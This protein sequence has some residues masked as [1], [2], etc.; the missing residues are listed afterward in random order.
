MFLTPAPLCFLKHLVVLTFC[1][2]LPDFWEFMQIHFVDGRFYVPTYYNGQPKSQIDSNTILEHNKLTGGFRLTQRRIKADT[3]LEGR[4][5]FKKFAPNCYGEL[6]LDGMFPTNLVEKG[7]F[8]GLKSGNAYKY[9]QKWFWDVGYYEEFDL[10]KDKT[11][12]RLQTLKED[13][14]IGPATQWARLDFVLYNPN[15]GMFAFVQATFEIRPTGLIVPDFDVTTRR[16]GY[17][18]AT[19]DWSRMAVELAVVVGWVMYVYGEIGDA[20]HLYK[21]SG[22]MLAYLTDFWNLVDLI[23]LIVNGMLI[24]IWIYMITD[25]TI[26]ELI[27]TET[28]MTMGNG[29]PLDFTRTAMAVR[30][31]FAM[32]GFNILISV[33][34]ILKFF[35]QNAYLGQLTDAFELMRPG[36][37]QFAVVLFISIFMFTAMG[38][39]LFGAKL[40]DFTAFL[41]AVD[42]IMG[43]T[44]GYSD[45]MD[46]FAADSIS[47]CVFYY[48]FT[49]L[50]AFFVLPLTIAVIMDGYS[51]M[52]TMYETARVTNLGDVIDLSYPSQIYRGFV[53]S[54]QFLYRH[55]YRH[56]RLKFPAK[57][58]IL[59]LFADM[60]K[61]DIVPFSELRK[62]F[63][64][65]FISEEMLV[66]VIR[67][68]NA[69]QADPALANLSAKNSMKVERGAFC[70]PHCPP[71]S[72]TL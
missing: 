4:G 64:D 44:V 66:E 48:P 71:P 29:L 15:V 18:Q 26:D 60:N 52:Q 22:K 72:Q 21:S 14:W 42:I 20:R 39:I 17:Y 59:R 54:T 38:V 12:A 8:Y 27:V 40:D 30:V 23:H 5:S 41:S 47:A 9:E 70:S 58:E 24:M 46:L 31:Y 1:L 61:V 7:T 33:I 16:S 6:Y 19:L 35:R 13:M 28:K 69:F 56:P 53:R 68:Y 43:Y 50:M 3:C 49:F 57:P 34:R 37:V 25:S 32:H 11:A 36:L 55:K 65:K 45:P 51:E 62:M 63:R 67:K 10:N 2:A